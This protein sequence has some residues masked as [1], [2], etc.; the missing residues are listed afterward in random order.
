MIVTTRRVVEH[1]RRSKDNERLSI[2]T[3]YET[4]IN[5]QTV[6]NESKYSKSHDVLIKQGNA[7]FY[8]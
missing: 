1:K 5:K 3:I 7:Y 2:I 8:K 4:G 6:R